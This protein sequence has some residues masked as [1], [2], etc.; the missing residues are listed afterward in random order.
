VNIKVYQVVP[1]LFLI[2]LQNI[3][4]SIISIIII[5]TASILLV[6]SITEFG[7]F[8]I[9]QGQGSN[10]TSSLLT[11]Q[12]KAAICNPNNPK[13]KFVN[14]TESGICGIPPTPTNTTTTPPAANA[15][16]TET[17][18]KILSP[19]T[20]KTPSDTQTIVKQSP[21]YEQGYAKGVA[22]ARSVQSSSP[23][24]NTTMNPDE[25]DCD[26]S[27]DPQASN[28]EYC[29]GYQHGFADTN[30]ELLGK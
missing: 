24:S 5:L 17:G 23:A 4:L 28:E 2:Y 9:A 18:T 21:L 16:S 3:S 15:M 27:I 22:D 11:P 1:S 29:S 13:L 6:V 25:V 12:Q 19:H 26:S 10:S 20:S 14:S 8:G 7:N 30:N